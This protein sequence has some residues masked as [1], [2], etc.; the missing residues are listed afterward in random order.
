MS[1]DDI[2]RALGRIEGKIEPLPKMAEDIAAVKGKVDNLPC[3]EHLQKISVVEQYTS[4]LAAEA[5]SA[6]PALNLFW[7]VIKYV[8]IAVIAAGIAAL[9]AGGGG[10]P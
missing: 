8:I 1:P 7:E 5:A 9:I 10:I 6:K 2:Q 4:A 3:D